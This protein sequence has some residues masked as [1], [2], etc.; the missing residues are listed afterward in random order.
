MIQC[1]PATPAAPTCLP[2]RH[3]E[4]RSSQAV[5]LHLALP[6]V[7][8]EVSFERGSPK[9]PFSL[10]ETQSRH[11]PGYALLEAEKYSSQNKEA[12]RAC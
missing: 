4:G 6:A 7:V 5:L 1:L 3:G 2:H 11:S 8:S 12:G 9:L 10:T